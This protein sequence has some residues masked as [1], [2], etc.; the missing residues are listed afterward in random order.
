M[1]REKSGEGVE[2]TGEL[3]ALAS[4]PGA[5][6]DDLTWRTCTCQGTEEA[7]DLMESGLSG[8]GA[9]CWAKTVSWK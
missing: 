4:A 8:A 2:G 3:A 1:S 5:P 7:A 9:N 6:P